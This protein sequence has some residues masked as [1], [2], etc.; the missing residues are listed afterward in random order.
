MFEWLWLVIRSRSVGSWRRRARWIR[1]RSALRGRARTGLRS[2]V[3]VHRRCDG[4]SRREIPSGHSNDRN[5]DNSDG[6][7]H[8]IQ[9][10]GRSSQREPR[11]ATPN[12][13]L[14]PLTFVCSSQAPA[15]TFPP[16]SWRHRFRPRPMP[17]PAPRSGDEPGVSYQMVTLFDDF[18]KSAHAV[19]TLFLW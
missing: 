16:V 4:H 14:S 18:R 8:R 19:G 3:R 2:H 5:H 1:G 10:L 9:F 7:S 12:W 6:P 11:E 13:M 15:R 17:V